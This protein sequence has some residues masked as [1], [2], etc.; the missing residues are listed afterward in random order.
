MKKTAKF[1]SNF[2]RKTKLIAAHRGHRAIRAEN[3]LSAFEASLEKAD[4]IEL[5]V[6]FTKDAVAIIIHDDTL[7]RTSNAS[8]LKE[9]KKPYSVVDYTYDEIKQLDFSSWFASNDPFGTI[10]SGA[11]TMRELK[12]LSIQRVSTLK[13]VLLFLKKHNFPVNVEIKDMSQTAFDKLATKIVADIVKEVEVENLVLFSSFNHNYIKEL[14]LLA[15]N[16]TRAALKHKSH[17]EDIVQYLKS[18]HVDGYHCELG[19]ANKDIIK[20][21]DKNNLFTNVYT[22]NS[23]SDKKRV[24]DMGARAIFTDFL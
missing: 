14:S 17:P 9:F 15:P 1:W 5:D 18:L 4:F 10:K 3:T 19:I 20:E 12:A 8:E 23:K 2:S 21:L 6:G 16:T 7:E 24:F 11:V 13:E 22:V